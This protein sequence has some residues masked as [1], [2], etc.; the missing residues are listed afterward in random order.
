MSG[1][2]CE[3]VRSIVNKHLSGYIQSHVREYIDI[4]ALIYAN[5]YVHPY[6]LAVDLLCTCTRMLCGI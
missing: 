6:V 4:F 3:W 5:V 1:R 2:Y